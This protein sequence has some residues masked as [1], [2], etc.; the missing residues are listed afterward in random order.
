MS[1]RV[2]VPEFVRRPAGDGWL[3][4]LGGGELTF[5]ET[6][7]ADAAWLAHAGPGPIGFVPAASGSLDYGRHFAAYLESE[8]G[9]LAEIVPIYRPRDARRGK[10]AERLAEC[11]AIYLGGG[12]ADHLL[13]AFAG[14]PAADAVLERL[15]TGGVVVAIAAAAQALGR[16]VRSIRVG[17]FVD[18]LDW[19]PGGVVET[20]FD[21]DHDRR[22]RQSLARPGVSWGLGIPSESAV[23]LGPGG[24]VEATGPFFAVAG[25][26]GELVEIEQP[27]PED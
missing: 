13:E 8:H 10:N 22:L 14:S 20:N 27:E 17:H 18:G 3:A 19:L 7:E 25:A 9:R 5:G 4:L 16:A 6:Y 21:P 11:A 12:V 24:A 1:A 15:R 2:E 23:L 26:D